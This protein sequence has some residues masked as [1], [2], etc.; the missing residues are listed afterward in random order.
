MQTERKEK[1]NKKGK[2]M[3]QQWAT[4]NDSLYGVFYGD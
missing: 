3:I 4:G 1:Y 2:V